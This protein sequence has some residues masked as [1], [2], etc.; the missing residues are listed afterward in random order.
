MGALLGRRP[1]RRACG[2]ANRGSR[3]YGRYRGRRTAPGRAAPAATGGA[4]ERAGGSRTAGCGDRDVGVPFEELPVASELGVALLELP[5]QI[6]LAALI[7]LGLEV[8]DGC[9]SL[10][11]GV[12]MLLGEQAGDPVVEAGDDGVLTDVDGLAVL[13]LGDRV[14]GREL[15]SVVRLAVVPR[16]L[17]L[18]V[19][20]RRSR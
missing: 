8:T 18:P 9:E 11:G 5:A 14:L 2:D 1:H 4:A 20:T 10:A 17:H 16:P 15:A 7:V 12:E 3:W 19:R 6:E 13:A